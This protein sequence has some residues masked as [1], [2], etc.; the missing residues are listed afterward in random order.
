MIV[1]RPTAR[2]LDRCVAAPGRLTAGV[3]V[4][5]C[6]TFGVVTDRGVHMRKDPAGQPGCERHHRPRHTRHERC[7][8]GQPLAKA[9]LMRVAKCAHGGNAGFEKAKDKIFMGPER[10]AWSC[11]G[12]APQHGLPR[13]GY[14]LI[15]KLLPKC[16]PVHKV[17]IIPARPCAWA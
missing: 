14:A 5:L 12:R 4:T 8:F 3:C 9:A 7:R 13:G 1:A 11:R 15:G 17:T 2:L 10:K 6:L 16:D